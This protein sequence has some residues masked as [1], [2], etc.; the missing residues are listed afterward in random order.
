MKRARRYFEV[1]GPRRDFDCTTFCE[2]HAKQALDYATEWLW[3][4][5]D[6]LDDGEEIAIKVEFKIGTERCFECEPVTATES[7]GR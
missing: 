6:A 3:E 5:F 4:A 7:E 1:S 2:D